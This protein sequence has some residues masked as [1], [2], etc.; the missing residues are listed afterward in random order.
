[1]KLGKHIRLFLNG[2]RVVI[3]SFLLN[4]CMFVLVVS[5]RDFCFET[6]DDRDI[7]NLLAD[8]Y[9]TGQGKYIP[10]INLIFC[11]A[12]SL[13]FQAFGTACNWY[14]V[15]LI[16]LGFLSLVKIC[17]ILLQRAKSI[18]FGFVLAVLFL[19]TVY[20]DYYIQ[21]QFTHYAVLCC[22]A[23]CLELA[24]GFYEEEK[25]RAG[26]VLSGIL[27][28]VT[29]SMIRFQA[30]FF[31][32]PYLGI[33]W[34]GRMLR[35]EGKQSAAEML[36]IWRRP[37]TAVF[38][39]VCLMLGARGFHQYVYAADTALREFNAYN[40]LRVELLD[41][42]LP[43]Y[44]TN[45]EEF[46]A[47]GIA[48]ADMECLN[49]QIF[50]DPD[51]FSRK[52]FQ[53]LADKKEQSSSVLQVRNLSAA[54]LK[55]VFTYIRTDFFLH[56]HWNAMLLLLVV[57]MLCA[58]KENVLCLAAGTVFGMACMWYF[59]SVDRMPYRI[60]CSVMTPLL[61]FGF[62]F[63][64]RDYGGVN[65]RE[66]TVIPKA[67]RYYGIVYLSFVLLIQLG[68]LGADLRDA[69]AD[70]ATD[71][72]E[73]IISFADAH[74]DALILLD[75]PTVSPLTYHSTVGVLEVPTRGSHRNICYQGGW[76]CRTPANLSVLEQYEGGN[77]YKA[78]ANGE[79]VYLVDAKSA[80][81]V[82]DYI[83][84]HYDAGAEAETAAYIGEAQIPVY[85][86][87][88]SRSGAE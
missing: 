63:L 24:D 81:R 18:Y 34:F 30:V 16:T 23:G 11:E 42:G 9:G 7:S 80:D 70:A 13:L 33:V 58:G 15:L 45:R 32:L 44:E 51:V 87:S 71:N 78:I 8:V 86:F 37:L 2:H 46:A 72:Y 77:P 69:S 29:G 31:V 79:T 82:L 12:V 17:R 22:S 76:I 47:L 5:M 83:R 41:Y 57:Y 6:N 55:K 35:R 54:G 75:R 21:F 19:A 84:R 85:R 68:R 40:Q 48:E 26:R 27:L 88:C 10:F 62:Y 38:A 73:A 14:A 60:W 28:F 36:C 74:P 52:A 61:I 50:L 1:M 25:L 59:L 64:A 53:A 66:K 65:G 20:A 67:L 3:V 39:A 4:L 56:P 49:H 43:D